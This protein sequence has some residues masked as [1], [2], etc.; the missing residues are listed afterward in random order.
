[1]RGEVDALDFVL[2]ERLG[3]TLAQVGE[4]PS[5]EVEAWRAWEVVR[6][7]TAG[8]RGSR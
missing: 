1:M 6:A 8:I 7:A 4:L 2:A 5:A 3:L